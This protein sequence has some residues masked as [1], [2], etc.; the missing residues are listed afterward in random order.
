MLT[1]GFDK[2]RPVPSSRGREEE[3]PG[4]EDDAG[5]ETLS[6]NFGTRKIDSVSIGRFRSSRLLEPGYQF[7]LGYLEG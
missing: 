3:R 6:E 2:L 1:D 5:H 7:Q 4:N